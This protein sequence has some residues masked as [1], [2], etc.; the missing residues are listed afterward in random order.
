M[1]QIEQRVLDLL[2]SRSA[3]FLTDLR[4]VLRVDDSDIESAISTLG[5]AVLVLDHR[6]PDS[7]VTGD[8]RIAADAT[9]DSPASRIAD[10][11]REFTRQLALSHRC[12]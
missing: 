8:F 3:L 6:F 4:A 7:H 12:S 10:R 2:A 11:W 9:S 1:K 5:D